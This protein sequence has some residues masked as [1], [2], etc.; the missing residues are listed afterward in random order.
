MTEPAAAVAGV[1]SALAGP[2]RHL[3]LSPHYD[4]IALSCGGTVA[5]LARSGPA[6]EIAVV[7]GDEP[8]PALPLT[9][10]ARALHDR[11]GLGA[12]EVIAARRRE[13]AAA[14]AA[15]GASPGNLPFLDAIYRGDAYQSNERLFA[16]PV[17]TDADLPVRIATALLL[18]APPDPKVRVYAP[19]AVGGHVDHRLA[20][21]AG[22]VL[23]RYGHRVWFYEDL[24]YALLPEA[25]EAR[26][27]ALAPE[28]RPETAA[29]V[30]VTATWSAK[31]AAILSYPSQLATV[32]GY[33]GVGTAPEAI[34][35][36]LRGYAGRAAAEADAI[37]APAERFWQIA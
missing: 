4:D 7:F 29:I 9:P 25:L 17:L 32:F 14:A 22:V 1:P 35:E 10:F 21:A 16:E 11:W 8:D 31:Q 20:F 24:P 5:L 18:D 26:L 36:A 37:T 3:F 30:D 19:L 2:S 27:A 12:R 28:L 13:E 33:A 6:P 34:D 15:L 23:A